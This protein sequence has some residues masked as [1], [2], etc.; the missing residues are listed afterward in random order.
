ML[1]MNGYIVHIDYGFILGISPGNNRGFE[2]APFKFTREYLEIL[3][4]EDSQVFEFFVSEFYKG[5][6]AARKYYTH[7]ENII[8]LMCVEGSSM[9]CFVGKKPKEVIKQFREKFYLHKPQI[10]CLEIV[11]NIIKDA[12]SSH[13]TSQYDYFQLLTNGILK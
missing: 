3:E 6:L 2:T 4:G 13:R 1:D 12:M 7:F 10:K 9:P 5:F 11:R 8:S